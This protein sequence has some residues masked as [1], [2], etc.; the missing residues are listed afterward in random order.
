MKN[1]HL[2]SIIKHSARENEELTFGIIISFV[3]IILVLTIYRSDD[4][5]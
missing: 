1:C 5:V 4:V 3:C 2:I